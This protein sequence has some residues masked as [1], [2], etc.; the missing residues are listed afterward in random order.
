MRRLYWVVGAVTLLCASVGVWSLQR[1]TSSPNSSWREHY[2]EPMPKPKLLPDTPSWVMPAWERINEL[3]RGEDLKRPALDE[4]FALIQAGRAVQVDHVPG[5][6]VNDEYYR[7]WLADRAA[8]RLAGRFFAGAPIDD[9]RNVAREFGRVLVEGLKHAR[10]EERKNSVSNLV[11]SKIGV[12]PE[13]RDELSKVA[14][15]PDQEVAAFARLKIT[16][17]N[18]YLDSARVRGQLP[19]DARNITVLP[20]P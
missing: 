9:V 3:T 19:A 18:Q 5:E 2:A 14:L 1:H 15:D 8:G 4:L 16:H 6:P 10:A 11:N 17:L 7:V 20:R 12:L 13:F